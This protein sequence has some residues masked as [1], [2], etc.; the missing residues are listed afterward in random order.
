VHPRRL[1]PSILK[2]IDVVIAAGAAPEKTL[3]EFAAASERPVAA[4]PGPHAGN[5]PS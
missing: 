3:Q 5:D 1:A 4:L 2:G